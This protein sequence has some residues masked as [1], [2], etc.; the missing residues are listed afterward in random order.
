MIDRMDNFDQLLKKKVEN[1]QFK[2]RSHFWLQYAHKAGF[3]AAIYTK[4]TLFTLLGIATAGG[5][6]FAVY[7]YINKDA[8]VIN[9]P[10]PKMTPSIVV[11]TTICIVEE[12]PTTVDTLT[13]DP[14]KSS[15]RP[16]PIEDPIGEKT[17]PTIEPIPEPTEVKPVEVKRDTVHV[18]PAVK[19]KRY[20]I[21]PIEINPD[22]I[23]SND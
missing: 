20:T 10:P 13:V 23:T 5:L 7:Q 4:F 18:K 16:A 14:R 6:G 17:E 8:A 19:R 3:S 11:D 9:Q 22:T 1:K 2:Y 21:R 12:T 15:E